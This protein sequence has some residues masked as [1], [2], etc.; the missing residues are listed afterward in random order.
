M[1]VGNG[2]NIV[3]WFQCHLIILSILFLIVIF[4]NKKKAFIILTV[5]GVN[6]YIFLTSNY[7]RKYFSNNTILL[8]SIRLLPFSYIY[9]LFGF[10][11]F[12]LNDF[13][14]FK[15]YKF[16]NSFICLIAFFLY[17]Y[18]R[19]FL[20]LEGCFLIIKFLLCIS[21]FIVFLN[22][23]L[24]ETNNNLIK[25]LTSYSGGIYYLH[26]KMPI[27]I[28]LIFKRIK[29]GALTACIINYLL[30]YLFC[31]IGSKLFKKSNLKYLFV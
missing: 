8:F 25:F 1:L 27:L 2:I 31:L 10:I 5:I 11:L 7:Y 23:P 14:K 18:K 20:E 19:I 17:I 22:F 6:L 9:A 16:K 12:N 28:K 30:C 24:H 3:F 21:V 26:K 13:V 15:K 4:A 29:E